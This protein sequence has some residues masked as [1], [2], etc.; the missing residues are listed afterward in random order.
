MYGRSR[1]QHQKLA[2]A[3]PACPRAKPVAHIIS[4]DLWYAVRDRKAKTLKN[5]SGRTGLNGNLNQHHLNM[6]QVTTGNELSIYA[7]SIALI[8]LK[9]PQQQVMRAPAPIELCRQ[10][11]GTTSRQLGS[12]RQ[13]A[14]RA[15]VCTPF[16]FALSPFLFLPFCAPQ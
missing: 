9:R 13:A 6:F 11:Q 15:K 14:T 4:D 16:V 12:S 2:T 8:G 5:P 7:T 10:Y 1:W 3:L